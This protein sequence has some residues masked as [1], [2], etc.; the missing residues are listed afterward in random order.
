MEKNFLIAGKDLPYCKDFVETISLSGDKV[1][2]ASEEIEKSTLSEEIKIVKWNKNSA[3]STRS[4]VIQAETL[5]GFVNNAILY[6]DTQNFSTKFGNMA[7]EFCSKACDEMIL[8][9][10]YLTLELLNRIEQHKS[11]CRLIFVLKSFPS[12]A[13]TINTSALKK[14]TSSVS[15]PLVSAAESSFATF[16]ENIAASVLDNNFA[17]TLLVTGN[18]QNETMQTD[19]T[20]ASWLKDYLDALDAKKNETKS[21]SWVKAG[22][23]SPNGFSLFGK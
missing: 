8:S 22:T 13:D 3:I 5:N 1:V 4:L 6:F 17:S 12:M 18:A 7:Q 21:I 10:Q 15:N 11:K 23:K 19:S 20:L 2:V 9:Y 16:A 14:V